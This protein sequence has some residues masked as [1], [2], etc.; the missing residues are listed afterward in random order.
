M[1][2]SIIITIVSTLVVVMSGLLLLYKLARKTEDTYQAGAADGVW[3]DAEK[4]RLAD[5]FI[6]ARLE[7]NS[8]LVSILKLIALFK[9][10][11]K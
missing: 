8:T 11:R 9:S 4:I 10:I 3:T 5:A 2:W 6:K 1:D 7:A